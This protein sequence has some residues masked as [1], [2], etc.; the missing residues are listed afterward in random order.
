MFPLTFISNHSVALTWT[1]ADP[2]MLVSIASFSKLTVLLPPAILN[3]TT[4]PES[5]SSTAQ[6]LPT[7]CC[8]RCSCI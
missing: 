7:A 6:R 5:S 4:L 2:L 8:R 1:V 3:S